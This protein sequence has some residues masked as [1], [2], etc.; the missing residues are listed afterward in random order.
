MQAMELHMR[1]SLGIQTF[2]GQ[3]TNGLQGTNNYASHGAAHAY[4]SRYSDIFGT[5]YQRT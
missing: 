3:R 5:A 4:K 1:I 2:L